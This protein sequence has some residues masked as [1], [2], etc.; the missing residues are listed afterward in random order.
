MAL[1][2]KVITLRPDPHG[3]IRAIFTRMSCNDVQKKVWRE[4]SK[5]DRNSAGKPAEK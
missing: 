1:G 4:A 5:S 2:S 3:T